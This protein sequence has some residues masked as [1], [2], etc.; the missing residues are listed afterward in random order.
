MEVPA[1]ARDIAEGFQGEQ[2]PARGGASHAG[3]TGNLRE[4]Q[5]GAVSA[6]G[7]QD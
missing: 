2:K 4:R 5:L 6:E 3:V 7:L 1:V